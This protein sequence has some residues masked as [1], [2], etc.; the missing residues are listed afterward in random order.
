M[1]KLVV[2]DIQKRAT[3]NS[4][5]SRPLISRIRS[6]IKWKKDKVPPFIVAMLGPGELFGEYEAYN[7]V[8]VHEF[9]LVCNSIVG[10]I[11][12]LD[13]AEFAKKIKQGGVP[14]AMRKLIDKSRQKRFLAY[15]QI[16]NNKIV[17]I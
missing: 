10:Q 8:D 6:E 3:H 17:K 16:I 2:L 1:K 15:R 11:L 9:T 7:K 13:K 5:T 4:E 12:V 14:D